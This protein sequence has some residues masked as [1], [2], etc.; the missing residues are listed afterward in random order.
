[1]VENRLKIIEQRS[2]LQK[3]LTIVK[4]PSLNDV[5][6]MYEFLDML[7]NDNFSKSRFFESRNLSDTPE[8]EKFRIIT[9]AINTSIESLSDPVDIKR[10]IRTGLQLI[11][12]Q[13]KILQHEY[14][15]DQLTGLRNFNYL[16]KVRDDF[17]NEN[18][19]ILFFDINNMKV[20]ND[21]FG[22]AYGNEVIA[23]FASILLSSVSRN[24]FVIRYGGDEFIILCTE[25][26]YVVSTILANVEAHCERNQYSIDY[27]VGWA[28][29]TAQKFSDTLKAADRDMYFNKRWMKSHGHT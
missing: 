15:F 20:Q 29:N 17:D 22:H 7:I 23:S 3:H 28:Y 14:M 12:E 11:N 13:Q 25:A 1:M 10:C 2:S 21:S 8:Q 18:A 26:P 6:L 19:A 16:N 24:E 9:Q 5:A 4:P 27:S